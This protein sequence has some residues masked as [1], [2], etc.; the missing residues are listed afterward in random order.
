MTNELIEL[1]RLAAEDH[2]GGPPSVEQVEALVE[3]V[4]ALEAELAARQPTENDREAQVE[5]AM[6][7]CIVSADIPTGMRADLVA[8][9]GVAVIREWVDLQTVV[10]VILSAAVPDAATEAAVAEG[11]Q[12]ID[13][14]MKRVEALEAEREALVAAQGAAPQAESEAGKRLSSEFR[15]DLVEAARER[16]QA[17]WADVPEGVDA[18][19][20]AQNVVSAQEFFWL[21]HAFP[22]LPSST[23]PQAG[24]L[25]ETGNELRDEDGDLI[26]SGKHL[27]ILQQGMYVCDTCVNILGINVRWD[28][29]GRMEGHPLPV[30]GEKP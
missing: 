4:D 6:R 22:V 13:Q 20:L 16:I 7:A 1:L 19:T 27:R 17:V 2:A 3:L 30:E 18:K 14:A 25:P 23:A 15:A 12:C 21:A 10:D 26:S 8:I 28:R 5:A 11:D 9:D 24:A 29:A